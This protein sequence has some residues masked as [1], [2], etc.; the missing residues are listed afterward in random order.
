M[1][2]MA[3]REDVPADV[4][5]ADLERISTLSGDLID[6]IG[7]IAWFI[8]P[9]ERQADQ[10]MDQMRMFATR[11][12]GAASVRFACEDPS[13][14]DLLPIEKRRDFMLIFKE[15]VRNASRHSGAAEIAV[16]LSGDTRHLELVV[17]DDGRGFSTDTSGNGHGRENMKL[18]AR[19]IGARLLF[20]SENGNGTTVRLQLPLSS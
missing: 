10:L 11:H 2:D 9:R 14:L 18:R 20:E 4:R 3:A 19:R 17:Q 6:A 8:Q 12:A 13:I 16:T 5:R 7:E 15:A 1:A